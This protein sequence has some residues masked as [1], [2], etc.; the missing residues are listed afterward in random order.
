[1]SNKIEFSAESVSVE[2]IQAAKYDAGFFG[3]GYEER[4]TYIP[5]LLQRNRLEQAYAL[6][7][8]DRRDA[9]EGGRS[10]SSTFFEEELSSEVVEMVSPDEE[11]LY[12]RCRKTGVE[13]GGRLLVDYSSMSKRWYNGILNWA[14]FAVKDADKSDGEELQ[15]DFAYSVGGYQEEF[16]PLQI[17]RIAPLP[18]RAAIQ[19]SHKESV[20]VFGLGFDNLVAESIHDQIEP[21][22]VYAFVASPGAS[23]DDKDKVLQKNEFFIRDYTKGKVIELPLRDVVQTAALLT[24]V[25]V[26]HLQHSSV[27]LIPLG[28]KPHVLACLLVCMQYPKYISCL[29]VKGKRKAVNVRPTGEVVGTRVTLRNPATSV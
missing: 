10:V 19:H 12:S 8:P 25:V 24:E 21:D 13:R 7:H 4:C 15:I 28:P 26:P 2:E 9:G 27:L 23:D 22:E 16:G 18:N 11:E 3:C 17:G 20:S 14:E 6:R 1:M 5:S 29:R